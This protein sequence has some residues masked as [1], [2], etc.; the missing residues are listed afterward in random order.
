M[1]CAN[2]GT[3]SSLDLCSFQKCDGKN[4]V[5]SVVHRFPSFSQ[6]D[7]IAAKMENG[8]L[9]VIFPRSTPETTLRKIA[10]T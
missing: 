9:T 4:N 7:E 10:V 6:D 2:G 1:P 5:L 3:A 8:I